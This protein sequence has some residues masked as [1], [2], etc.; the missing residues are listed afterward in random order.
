MTCEDC[1]FEECICLDIEKELETHVC[2]TCLRYFDTVDDLTY[3]MQM[4]HSQGFEN[5]GTG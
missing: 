1:Q 2:D 3:H 5:N 4:I